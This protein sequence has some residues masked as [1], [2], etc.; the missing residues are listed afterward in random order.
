MTNK[1]S[2]ILISKCVA[3]ATYTILTT[4]GP[5]VDHELVKIWNALSYDGVSNEVK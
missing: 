3:F 4:L 1:A 2:S 5:T